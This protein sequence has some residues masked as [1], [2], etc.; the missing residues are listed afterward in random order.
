L[1]DHAAVEL[2]QSP[3]GE[4]GPVFWLEEAHVILG[5]SLQTFTYLHVAISLIGIGAGILVVIGMINRRRLVAVTTLFLI[6]TALTSLTGF[7]FPFKGMTPGIVIGSLSMIVLVL[8][9]LAR[10]RVQTSG[11][12]RDHVCD[13]G[14]AG[15]LL[16]L[17]CFGRTVV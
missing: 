14:G 12:W 5:I 6:T 10:R 1:S 8:A 2:A 13:L 16:Q 17:L 4:V 11:I 3:V 7:L 9:A 15:S